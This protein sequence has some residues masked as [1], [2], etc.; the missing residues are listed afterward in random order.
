MIGM[1]ISLYICCCPHAWAFGHG[2]EMPL[3]QRTIGPKLWPRQYDLWV[4]V[5]LPSRCS[6]K[7]L[8]I[9]L[10]SLHLCTLPM[11][12]RLDCRQWSRIVHV[13]DFCYQTWIVAMDVT[14]LSL[15]HESLCVHCAVSISR[16][17]KRKQEWLSLLCH[18]FLFWNLMAVWAM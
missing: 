2:S 14:W 1:N 11:Y 13:H 7:A 10:T 8:P 9:F 16:P 18:V 12:K 6:T 5:G 3:S 4:F 15:L 17:K